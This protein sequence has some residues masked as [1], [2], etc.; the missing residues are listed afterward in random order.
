ATSAFTLDA[1]AT[2]TNLQ[3]NLRTI[4]ALSGVLVTGSNGGPF[5]LTFAGSLAGQNVAAPGPTGLAATGGIATFA[6]VIDGS[7]TAPVAV[8][9]TTGG[10]LT[11]TFGGSL[12]STNLS[13][14]ASDTPTVATTATVIDG[15]ATP[16]VT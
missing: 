11:I 7:A 12:A 5:T 16:P 2:A 13:Q 9:G 1:S 10:T 6:N 8:T 3:T 4:S 14:I 15:N